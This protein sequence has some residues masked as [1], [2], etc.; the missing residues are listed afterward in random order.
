M[1]TETSKKIQIVH[2]ILGAFFVIAGLLTIQQRR[3]LFTVWVISLGVLL[4]FQSLKKPLE[5]KINRVMLEVIYFII[6]AVV[7]LSG[8]IVLFSD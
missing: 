6:S 5:S 1:D 8:V 3:T 4:L 7:L 2:V